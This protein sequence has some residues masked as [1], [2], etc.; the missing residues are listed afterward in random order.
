MS[1]KL[2]EWWSR[3]TL[4]EQQELAQAYDDVRDAKT[5]LAKVQRKLKR[6]ADGRMK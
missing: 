1:D 4:A 6:R 5:S 3:L 2:P